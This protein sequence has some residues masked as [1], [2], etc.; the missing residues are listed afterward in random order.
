MDTDGPEPPVF[1]AEVP[2]LTDTTALEPGTLGAKPVESTRDPS[3]LTQKGR[4]RKAV[5]W[6]EG[7][8]GEYF[9][10]ELDGTD[11]QM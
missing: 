6:P 11:E 10:F 1:P 4:K 9:C 2:E 3:Q 7:K 5:M 8:L